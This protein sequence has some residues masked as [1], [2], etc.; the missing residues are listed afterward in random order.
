MRVSRLPALLVLA[1]ATSGCQ[2][3]TTGRIAAEADAALAARICARAWRPV[4]YDSSADSPGTVAEARANNRA[5]AAF[6]G[7]ARA[8]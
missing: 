8:E 7:E 6:C 1:L 2:T 3:L 4:T 5:R